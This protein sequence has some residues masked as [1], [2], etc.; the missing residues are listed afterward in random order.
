VKNRTLKVSGYDKNEI[1]VTE[2]ENDDY[3]KDYHLSQGKNVGVLEFSTGDVIRVWYDNGSWHFHVEVLS[4]KCTITNL[5]TSQAQEENNT[6]IFEISGPIEEEV[7]DPV[8]SVVFHSEWP[9]SDDAKLEFV[10]EKF[11]DIS[12]SGDLDSDFLQIMYDWF[13]RN[14]INT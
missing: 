11:Q 9:V 14:H 2:Q 3:L 7:W 6:D 8:K 10:M 1:S 5:M 4:G 13:L 12:H